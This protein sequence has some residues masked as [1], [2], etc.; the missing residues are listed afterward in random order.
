MSSPPS[1][2]ELTPKKPESDQKS[3]QKTDQKSDQKTDQGS[4]ASTG[5]G[6]PEIKF[7]EVTL[8]R[9]EYKILQ[10]QLSHKKE[11]KTDQERENK[12]SFYPVFVIGYVIFLFFRENIT[13]SDDVVNAVKFVMFLYTLYVISVDE[14]LRELGLS[15]PMRIILGACLATLLILASSVL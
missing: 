13:I 9:D 8:T 1:T 6:A 7:K 10:Q 2:P 5:E 3:D 11:E 14:N 15:Y 4:A 12:N